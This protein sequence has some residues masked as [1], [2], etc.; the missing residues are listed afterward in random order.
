[1]DAD[2]A[3]LILNRTWRPALSITGIEGLPALAQAGNVTIPNLSVKLSM[4]I[5]PSCDGE[6]ALNA[7]S[8]ALTTDTPYSAKVTFAPG[9]RGNGWQAPLLAPWLKAA[10]DHASELFFNKSAAYLGEGGKYPF[11]GHVG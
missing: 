10:N 3:E 2:P 5:P 8:R 4:R 11:Y 1:M 7:L 6:Q 9:D